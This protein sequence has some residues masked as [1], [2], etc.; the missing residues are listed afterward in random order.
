MY[1]K[2]RKWL[3][4]K[5]GT[6]TRSILLNLL[7]CYQYVWVLV[8]P[9]LAVERDLGPI[10]FLRVVNQFFFYHVWKNIY[11]CKLTQ[12]KSVERESS[13][14]MNILMLFY[15][16]F[17]WAFMYCMSVRGV[18]NISDYWQWTGSGEAL[19]CNPLLNTPQPLQAAL[20]DTHWFIQACLRNSKQ[21]KLRISA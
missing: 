1:F 18:D 8:N 17:Y 9:P 3:E 16:M 11:C 6:R 5:C 10:K 14:I 4:W 2:Q 20:D 15:V 19:I 13:L 21:S 12:L 7:H